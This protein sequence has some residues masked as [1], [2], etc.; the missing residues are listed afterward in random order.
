MPARTSGA[1]VSGWLVIRG[2]RAS[3]T[4]LTVILDC[5]ADGRARWCI[6]G[7]SH[8]GAGVCGSPV[9]AVSDCYLLGGPGLGGIGQVLDADEGRPVGDLCRVR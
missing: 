4:A 2:Q 3:H 1:S 9:I 5:A 6:R 8:G 7:R